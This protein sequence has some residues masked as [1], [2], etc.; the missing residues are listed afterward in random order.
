[1]CLLKIL[2]QVWEL[3]SLLTC[4]VELSLFV[5]LFKF[6]PGSLAPQSRI[7]V[8]DW[9]LGVHSKVIRLYPSLVPD[10]LCYRN[11]CVY[12]NVCEKTTFMSDP[13]IKK[14]S[15][16]C[17]S[18]WLAC[19]TCGGGSNRSWPLLT[20]TFII[21]FFSSLYI[22]CHPLWVVPGS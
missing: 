18:R 4:T 3:D 16:A 22:N 14:K 11:S 15:C 2:K 21:F 13:F 8:S 6:W 5:C 17:W 9:H 12:A 7:A 10:P 19:A 1:M 20:L